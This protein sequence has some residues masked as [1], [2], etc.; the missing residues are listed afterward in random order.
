MKG[1]K[2]TALHDR[3]WTALDTA[4]TFPATTDD[5]VGA[6]LS[7]LGLDDLDAAVERARVAYGHFAAKQVRHSVGVYDT[8][9]RLALEAALTATSESENTD[10]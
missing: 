7:C 3:L 6:A 10:A 4:R 1:M 5:L 9:M 8:G 2:D